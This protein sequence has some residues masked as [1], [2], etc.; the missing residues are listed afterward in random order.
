MS[1]SGSYIQHVNAT[2]RAHSQISIF[3]L[4]PLIETSLSE[5]VSASVVERG[6]PAESRVSLMA[7]W[8]V[9]SGGSILSV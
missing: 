8:S 7:L 5:F 6:A 2:T 3:S 9:I 1:N 4:T